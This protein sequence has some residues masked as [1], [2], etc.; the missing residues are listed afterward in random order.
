MKWGAQALIWPNRAASRLVA[1]RPH[2]WHVQE[3]GTGPSLLLLHGA[4]GTTHSWRD[5]MPLLA[6]RFHV[7]ALD[8]PGQGFTRMGTRQRSGLAPCA[9]DIAA[10]AAQEGW[11]FDVLIG[12]SAGAALALQLA[13][14]LDPPPAAVIG[15]NAALEKFP[16]PAEWAFPMLAKLL[17]MN[18]LVST[19][20]ASTVATKSS[21]RAL[22]DSTGSKLDDAGLALYRTAIS[23]RDHVDAT[24]N[25]MA[26]WDLDKLRAQLPDLDVPCLLLAADNDRA[27]PPDTSDRA[28]GLLPQARAVRLPGLGHLAHEEAPVMVVEQIEAYL[29]PILSDRSGSG[30]DGQ[31]DRAAPP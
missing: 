14:V 8:L 16:G 27:V 23:D 19:L 25:M 15:L 11:R 9:T 20:F 4:G 29:A 21:V 2:R 1:C 6:E 22:I 3:M 28:A 17:S 13:R 31:D 5:V 10:L 30:A 12:H 24:L 18:P 7:V 26:Q